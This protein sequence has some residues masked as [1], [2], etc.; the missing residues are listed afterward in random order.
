M[1]WSIE[2]LDK[3]HVVSHFAC[4]E[5]PLDAYLVKHALGNS[6]AGLGRT[7]VALELGGVDVQGYFTLAAGSVQFDTIPDHVRMRLPRY[8]IPTAHLAR[9]AVHG[10]S[11]GRKLGETLLVEALKR[12][13]LASES[14]GLFAVDVLASTDRAR[15]FYLKYGFIPLADNPLHLYLHMKTARRVAGITGGKAP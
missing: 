12:A 2:P 14:V 15:A 5:A 8:P 1:L 6:A 11:Q 13:A 7:F 10:A 3:R 4:G 9:L